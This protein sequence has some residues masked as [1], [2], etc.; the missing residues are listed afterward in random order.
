MFW[1]MEPP[2]HFRKVAGHVFIDLP[3]T[4]LSY[5]KHGIASTIVMISEW[6]SAE[7]ITDAKR[8][9]HQKMFRI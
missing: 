6:V 9:N 4:V 5:L 2:Q 3:D 7:L 8:D 1:T